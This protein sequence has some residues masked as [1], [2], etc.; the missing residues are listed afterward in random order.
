MP[1]HTVAL[2]IIII[3]ILVVF[4]FIGLRI[5]YEIQ[6]IV[7]VANTVFKAVDFVTNFTSQIGEFLLSLVD[8]FAEG[9]SNIFDFFDFSVL[10][11]NDRFRESTNDTLDRN[12]FDNLVERIENDKYVVIVG[13][14]DDA[15]LAVT[16]ANALQ[17]G[18]DDNKVT[19]V[20]FDPDLDGVSV[21]PDVNT[22]QILPRDLDIAANM[23]GEIG[24]PRGYVSVSDNYFNT[25]YINKPSGIR[26][27][28]YAKS[29]RRGFVY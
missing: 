26:A 29:L 20:L 1:F 9:L 23:D 15:P 14:G 2:I 12:V 22:I 6:P 11:I 3:V 19:L 28:D 21:N 5:W 27:K 13:I 4:A 25:Y 17:Q 8:R 24:D 7:K 16:Y 18:L 10:P